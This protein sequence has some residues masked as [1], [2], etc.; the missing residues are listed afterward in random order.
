MHLKTFVL[1]LSILSIIQACNMTETS[2]HVEPE[3]EVSKEVYLNLNQYG[4]PIE[5]ATIDT[6][7]QSVSIQEK[8]EGLNVFLSERYHVN[9]EFD[10]DLALKKED[11]K[12]DLLYD[13]KIVEQNNDFIIYESTLPDQSKS[14]MHFY[15]VKEI[16]G[17][18]FGFSDAQGKVGLNINKAHKMIE[19]LLK[20]RAV[21]SSG[22]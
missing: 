7:D 1:S 14:F 3:Q 5:L 20:S 15:V 16:S 8:P 22:I 17:E 9:V 18:Y 19:T 13:N 4:Y 11:L 12:Q 6:T 2:K 21:S 10:A